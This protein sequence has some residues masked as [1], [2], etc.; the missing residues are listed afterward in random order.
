MFSNFTPYSA[1][2]GGSLIGISASLL[3]LFNG[4]ICG[5]SGIMSSSLQK[6]KSE[7]LWR[8]FFLGGLLVGGYTVFSLLPDF[9]IL[10]IEASTPALILSGLLVGVGAKLGSGCTSGHGVCGISRLSKRSIAATL[11]FMAFGAL[12]VYV[13]NQFN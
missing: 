2:I 1:L 7:S 11:T 4:K 12:T 3:L 13:L 5:I 6:D 8:L 10:T 9:E